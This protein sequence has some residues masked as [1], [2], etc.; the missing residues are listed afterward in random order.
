MRLDI[1]LEPIGETGCRVQWSRRF[2][3]C[4]AEGNAWI[5][6]LVPERVAGATRMIAK[7]V[8]YF[9]ETGTMLRP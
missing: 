6:A 1:R 2:V 9:L 4:S 5:D 8:A 7:L 3:A